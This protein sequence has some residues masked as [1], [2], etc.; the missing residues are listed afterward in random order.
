[1]LSYQSHDVFFTR[2][3]TEPCIS[4]ISLLEQL[5]NHALLKQQN[6]LLEQLLNH[7]LLKQHDSVIIKDDAGVSEWRSG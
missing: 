6:S 1:M 3:I 5:L 7:A 2:T 4:K